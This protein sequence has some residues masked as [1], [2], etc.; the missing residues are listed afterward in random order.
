VGGPLGSRVTAE[1]VA[2]RRGAVRK[3]APWPVGRGSALGRRLAGAVA[4]L[5]GLT[6]IGRR[7][8]ALGPYRDDQVLAAVNKAA[9][10][11]KAGHVRSPIG[12]LI[13]KARQGDALFFSTG[14]LA[15]PNSTAS[16]ASGPPVRS[17]R[18][19]SRTS[20][21]GYGG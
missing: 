19:R 15:V 1:S 6:D 2:G 17:R 21:R 16:V 20:S 13:T 7:R 4:V 10:M 14:G 5:V 3:P 18:S 8:A 12:W 9:G 11:A